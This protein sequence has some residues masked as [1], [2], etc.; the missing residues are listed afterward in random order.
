MLYNY[1]YGV[2]S[3]ADSPVYGK[4]AGKMSWT[5]QGY[6]PTNQVL[7]GS[8][9]SGLNTGGGNN[10]NSNPAPAPLQNQPS[11]EQILKDQYISE[12]NSLYG[13]I[14]SGLD[15]QRT[16]QEQI[17]TNNYNQGLAD[18]STQKQIGLSDLGTQERKLQESQK[19]TLSSLADNLRNAYM[20][21]NVYL[22]ARGAGDSSA[23]NMYSYA[24]TKLGNKQRGDVMSQTAS[25]TNDI[26]DREYKLG[27]TYQTA[28]KQLETEKQ[29]QLLNI[30]TWFYDAQNQIRTTKAG[31]IQN[32]SLSL[33]QN[34]I[35]RLNTIDADYRNKSQTLT[36]WAANNSTNINQLKS[37]LAQVSNVAYPTPSYSNVNYMPTSSTNNYTPYV[38]YNTSTQE[39]YDLYGNKIS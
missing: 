7:S 28:Q 25:Y 22:G 13:T 29:N 36:T 3:G 11:P 12:L 30:A 31:N 2:V 21:G 27:L 37:N 32:L 34:A 15:P 39:K 4:T 38:P 10:I 1:D 5:N 23:A 33:L 18:L 17:V 20:A 16:S 6:A 19:K 14:E 8:T 26:R 35:N 24:L 9:S